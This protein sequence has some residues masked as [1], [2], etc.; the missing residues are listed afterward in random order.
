[1]VAAERRF[2]TGSH[3]AEHL[4]LVRASAIDAAGHWLGNLFQRLRAV[5]QELRAQGHVAADL[6]EQTTNVLDE[7]L[8]LLLDYV[9][10]LVPKLDPVPVAH[11]LARLQRNLT[12]AFPLDASL[13]VV[14]NDTPALLVNT[15]TLVAM[16]DYLSAY[17]RRVVPGEATLSLRASASESRLHIILSCS[18]E[19]CVKHSAAAELYEA[20]LVRLVEALGGEWECRDARERK[21]WSLCLPLQR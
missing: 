9:G 21:E 18:R 4:T 6:L 19:G 3:V 17:L 15:D 14:K 13:S 11:V 12:T 10:P 5:E 7:V 1:M 16:L 8:H 20:V 2:G